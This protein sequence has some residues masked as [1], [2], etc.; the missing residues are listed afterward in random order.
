MFQIPGSAP[1]GVAPAPAP[2]P[3]MSP[4]AGLAG[5]N[6]STSEGPPFIP[7]G[8]GDFAFKVA[9][10]SFVPA[11]ASKAALN[12][13]LEV[14]DTGTYRS[15]DPSKA[16]VVVP[17]AKV[18]YHQGVDQ[19]VKQFQYVNAFLLAAAGYR[20]SDTVAKAQIAPYYTALL[21]AARLEQ[22]QTVGTTV[23]PPE[24]I[25]GRPGVCSV[26]PGQKACKTGEIIPFL[27]WSPGK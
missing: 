10:V 18:R 3:G 24:A 11:G 5:V 22:P 2:A 16:G 27:T 9:K 23:I 15:V 17:G 7:N 25:L 26:R 13:D 21:D 1:A 19:P 12:F 20:A 4:F 6:P 14:T 8:S